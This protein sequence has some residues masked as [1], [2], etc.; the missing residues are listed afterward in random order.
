MAQIKFNIKV[1]AGTS[2]VNITPK[3]A[4]L[5]PGD[6]VTFEGTAGTSIKFADGTP[7]NENVN[8]KPLQLPAGPYTVKSAKVRYHFQ[9]GQMVPKNGKQVFQEWLGGGGDTPGD[10]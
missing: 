8:G 2:V 4:L 9:C 5:Q 10:H 7:F 1:N 3:N 6:Q